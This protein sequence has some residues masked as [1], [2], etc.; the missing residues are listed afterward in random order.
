MRDSGVGIDVDEQL[1][2]FEKFYEVGEIRHHS[3]S[4]RKFL[5]KGTGLGLTIVKG[6][7]EAHGG[8]VWVESPAQAAGSSFFV[9]LP[10]E[11]NL[12]QPAFSFMGGES[13]PTSTETVQ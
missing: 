11:E 10:L 7:V 12:R 4:K 1:K 5:G 8:M 2:I 3:S 13:V 9:L 6:M